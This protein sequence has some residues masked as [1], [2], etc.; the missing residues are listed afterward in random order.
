MAKKRGQVT[1][2]SR[3]KSAAPASSQ[4]DDLT[5]SES[6]NKATKP[7]KKRLTIYVSKDTADRLEMAQI[8]VKQLTDADGYITKISNLAEIAMRRLLDDFDANPATS[9]LT[10]EIAQ[11]KHAQDVERSS[12]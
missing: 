8:R 2:T 5:T 4:Q 9:Y 12:R 11:Q 6:D 7:K 1:L 10:Q 3:K